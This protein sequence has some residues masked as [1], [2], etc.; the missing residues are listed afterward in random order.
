MRTKLELIHLVKTAHEITALDSSLDKHLRYNTLCI[1]LIDA[2]CKS[3]LKRDFPK[4]LHEKIE[5]GRDGLYLQID[6]LTD[7]EELSKISEFEDA[8]EKWSESECGNLPTRGNTGRI[9]P[10]FFHSPESYIKVFYELDESM[11]PRENPI[12]SEVAFIEA[13]RK[14]LDALV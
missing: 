5:D 2:L 4:V 9:H 11:V 14:T 6:N 10:F 3:I 1:E 12:P 8:F 13:F 7:I